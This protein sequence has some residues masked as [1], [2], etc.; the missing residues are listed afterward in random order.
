MCAQA[1]P[2]GLTD[3]A[4]QLRAPCLASAEQ[5]VKGDILPFWMKYTRNTEDQGFYGTITA[6]MT[7]R[8]GSSRGALLTSRILWTFSTAYRTR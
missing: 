4:S 1:C 8:K 3:A 7:V 5:E 6:D 2:R